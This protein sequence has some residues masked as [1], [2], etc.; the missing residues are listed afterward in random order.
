MRRLDI[1]NQNKT[2]RIAS[3]PKARRVHAEPLS[4]R[5]VLVMGILSMW[6]TDPGIFMTGLYSMEDH[7]NWNNAAVK[8]WEA[9]FDVSVKMSVAAC[10]EKVSAETFMTPPVDEQSAMMI[11]VVKYSL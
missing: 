1:D 9:P 6:R 11:G 7:I 10:M 2:K 3:R 8:L 4:D 5:E